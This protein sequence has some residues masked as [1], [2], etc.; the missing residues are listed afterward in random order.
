MTRP[1]RVFPAVIFQSM[2]LIQVEMQPN[3]ATFR[4]GSCPTHFLHTVR[5]KISGKKGQL[6]VLFG[7]IPAFL[8]VFAEL[9]LKG[10]LVRS[11]P[12]LN[13]C[14]SLA[15][16]SEILSVDLFFRLQEKSPPPLTPSLNAS[17]AY[18]LWGNEATFNIRVSV[19]LPCV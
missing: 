17:G 18:Q 14:K 10:S 2:L 13:L 9:C 12:K 15:R 3:K 8:I 5:I 7:Y 16:N 19:S 1:I 6:T 4:D 11:K